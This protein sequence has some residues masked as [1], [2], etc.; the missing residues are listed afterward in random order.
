MYS[1]AYSDHIISD[2]KVVPGTGYLE[3]ALLFSSDQQ[4]NLSALTS[5]VFVKPC[6]I[7]DPE[8]SKLVVS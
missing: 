5:V 4:K 8:E 2:T 7:S 1:L 6:I 3:L